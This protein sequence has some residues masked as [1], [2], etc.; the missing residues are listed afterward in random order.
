VGLFAGIKEEVEEVVRKQ[1][2]KDA[3]PSNNSVFTTRDGGFEIPL[4]A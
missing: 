2:D 3:R 4:E 1:W